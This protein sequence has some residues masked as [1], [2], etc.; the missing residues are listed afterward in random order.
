MSAWDTALETYAR[1]VMSTGRRVRFAEIVDIAPMQTMKSKAADDAIDAEWADDHDLDVAG[2]E[3]AAVLADLIREL[4][5]QVDDEDDGPYRDDD[6]DNTAYAQ[7]ESDSFDD[8]DD[9]CDVASESSLS[10]TVVVDEIKVDEQPRIS[11]AWDRAISQSVALVDTFSQSDGEEGDDVWAASYR[12]D[13][14]DETVEKK[15]KKPTKVSAKAKRKHAGDG[16]AAPKKK[17]T[18]LSEQK[19][20]LKAKMTA[21]EQREVLR[22]YIMVAARDYAEYVAHVAE[23]SARQDY[24]SF[25]RRLLESAGGD[26]AKFVQA[27]I[28]LESDII[29]TIVLAKAQHT[30]QVQLL[31]DFVAGVVEPPRLTDAVPETATTCGVTSQ[32]TPHADLAVATIVAADGTDAR[33]L[34]M[35]KPIRNLTKQLWFLLNFY[36]LIS[37]Q[38]A[39]LITKNHWSDKSADELVDAIGADEDLVESI[40]KKLIGA[41][42]SV[43]NAASTLSRTK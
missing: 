19:D 6:D 23:D 22:A 30:E 7:E 14:E 1:E 38:I 36:A 5:S 18:K 32:P 34:V 20:A 3:Q 10:D 11:G 37:A 17:G 21:P 33:C 29:E 27:V 43:S 9:K 15:K 16:D 25:R 13:F 4:P 40:Y 31:C 12:R 39:A 41:H 2:D 35:R 28:S 26:D 24:V 42:T 8:D